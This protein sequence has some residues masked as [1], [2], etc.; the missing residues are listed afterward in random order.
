MWIG[1]E[2]VDDSVEIRDAGDVKEDEDVDEETSRWDQMAEATDT[3]L[4]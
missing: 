4:W 2:E 1:I 3:A